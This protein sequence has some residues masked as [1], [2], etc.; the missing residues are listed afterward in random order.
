MNKVN[1][2]KKQKKTRKV[3]EKK[4]KIMIALMRQLMKKKK[5]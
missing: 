5:M 3:K 4:P 1:K 2:L